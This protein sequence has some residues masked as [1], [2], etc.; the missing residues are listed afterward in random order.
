M[1]V[2]IDADNLNH[3]FLLD[4]NGAVTTFDAPDAGNVPGSLQGTLPWGINTNGAI[5]GWYVDEAN[6]NHALCVIGTAPSL[7]STFRA[8]ARASARSGALLRTGRWPDFTST[9]TM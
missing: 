9:R 1:G 8:R 4:K 7:S 3:S 6:V 2:L 5:T